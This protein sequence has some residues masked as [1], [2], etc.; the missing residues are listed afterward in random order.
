MQK[1]LALLLLVT[2]VC[3]L[4]IYPANI[5][6]QVGTN[7]IENNAITSPKI[8]DGAVKTPD[9]ASNAVTSSKISN[10]AVGTNDLADDSV[11][12]DKIE[13]GSITTADL[14]PSIINAETEK[15][16]TVSKIIFSSCTI[17]FPSIP[18]QHFTLGLCR[19]TGAQIGDK[20]I[21][22]SQNDASGIVTQSASVNA[23]DLVRMSVRNPNLIATHPPRI[24]WAVIIFRQ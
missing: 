13:D 21:V 3:G 17:D 15:L 10:G 23:T 12:S 14:S 9:I 24:T 2:F 22:T 18:A 6:A 8:R 16:K 7:N 11:T 4:Y 5:N 1:K 19:V 20:V